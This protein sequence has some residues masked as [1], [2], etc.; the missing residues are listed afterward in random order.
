MKRRKVTT[1]V[2]I[3][4]RKVKDQILEII[5]NFFTREGVHGITE[6]VFVCVDE[7]IKNAVKANYKFM[8]VLNQLL[9]QYREDQPELTEDELQ[10]QIRTVLR[11]KSSFDIIAPE[12]YRE[13]NIVDRVQEILKE[14]AEQIRIKDKAYMGDR[15]CTE[16][17]LDKIKTLH[18]LADLKGKLKKNNVKVFLKI[19]ADEEFVFIE[20]TNT[21]PITD[22]DMHRIHEKRDEFRKYRLEGRE[23]EFFINNIDTSESGYGLGYATIDSTLASL[24]LDPDESI[25]LLAASDTTV[26]LSF[27]I[28]DLIRKSA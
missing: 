19:E 16:E 26:I 21:A 23:Y 13:Y 10:E 5:D 7:L 8:F 6:D 4:S 25:K 11:D 17:E 12:I 3:Y 18:K 28:S 1:V 20:V 27:P 22:M 15:E 14:E 9:E 24:G 2:N